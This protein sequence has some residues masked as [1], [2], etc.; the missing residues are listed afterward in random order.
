M[1]L[2]FKNTVFVLLSIESTIKCRIKFAPVEKAEALFDKS[3]IINYLNVV[4]S[5]RLRR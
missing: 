3:E 4:N 5:A 1:T 2:N